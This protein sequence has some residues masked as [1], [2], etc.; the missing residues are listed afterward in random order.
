VTQ[1]AGSSQVAADLAG[2]T[3]LN[4]NDPGIARTF[5][6]ASGALVGNLTDIRIELTGLT[7]TWAGDLMAEIV[8][9]DG[10]KATVFH[11]IGKVLASGDKGDASDFGGG[12]IYRF[13]DLSTNSIWT[14]ASAAAETAPIAAGEYF[15]TIA[16][17]SS[18]VAMAPV[19]AGKPLVG[20]WTFRIADVGTGES[21]GGSVG[22]IKVTLVA[23]GTAFTGGMLADC[24]GDGISDLDAIAAGSVADCDEDGEV[25]VCA[26][27]RGVVD[28]TNGNGEPDVCEH[29]RG[30]LDLDGLVDASDLAI[31][32]SHWA[33]GGARPADG[34]L[35]GDGVVGA[36]DLASLV[37]NMTPHQ[38]TG[39]ATLPE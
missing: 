24:D 15:A 12:N 14:A 9:P 33:I 37:G 31:L 27:E 36:E 5:T 20:T 32:L 23:G 18:K 22:A 29:L 38:S 11:R 8:G 25:D 2:G 21:A 26:I 4:N 39:G 30:D 28:D 6:V 19:F 16:L 3:I 17:S 34:D 1:A 7:H 13:S 35:D 10:S